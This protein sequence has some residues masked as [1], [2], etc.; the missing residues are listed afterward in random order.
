MKNNPLY[1]DVLEDFALK[2]V[3]QEKDIARFLPRFGTE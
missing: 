1:T 3:K 2:N